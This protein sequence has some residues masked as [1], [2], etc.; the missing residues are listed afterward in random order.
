MNVLEQERQIEADLTNKVLE[1]PTML[2][3]KQELAEIKAMLLEQ[4]KK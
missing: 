4:Q 3:L 1:E 2:E